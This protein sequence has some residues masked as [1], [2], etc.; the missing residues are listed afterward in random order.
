MSI[1]EDLKEIFKRIQRIQ[2]ELGLNE[3]K[4]DIQKRPDDYEPSEAS[5]EVEKEYVPEIKK[6]SISNTDYQSE[7]ESDAETDDEEVEYSTG[8]EDNKSKKKKKKKK[9]GGVNKKKKVSKKKSS[10]KKKVTKK[11]TKKKVKGGG[12]NKFNIYMKKTLKEL[13]K[14]HPKK[15]HKERFKMAASSYKKSSK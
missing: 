3:R 4:N 5:S 7:N 12:K 14:K 11:K 9:R 10:K 1:E 15:S 6:F 13:K 8:S 2:K